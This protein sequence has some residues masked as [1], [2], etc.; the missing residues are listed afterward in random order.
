MRDAIYNIPETMPK[1]ATSRTVTSNG[2]Y[3]YVAKKREPFER[4]QVNVRVPEPA[5]QPP[6][7]IVVKI[8]TPAEAG[9][10]VSYIVFQQAANL[11]GTKKKTQPIP[12]GATETIRALSG[13]AIYLA[14]AGTKKPDFSACAESINGAVMSPNIANLPIQRKGPVTPQTSITFK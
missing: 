5:Q 1:A 7:E 4:V 9:T 11:W 8:T 3:V 10:T 6:S 2:N 14:D 13:T 12:A